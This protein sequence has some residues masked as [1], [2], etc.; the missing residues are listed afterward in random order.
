MLGCCGHGPEDSP[1]KRNARIDWTSIAMMVVTLASL[2]V[3]LVVVLR[4]QGP[5]V[6]TTVP[7]PDPKPGPVERSIP[8]EQ[9]YATFESGKVQLLASETSTDLRQIMR[10]SPWRPPDVFLIRAGAKD[11]QGVIRAGRG[12]LLG[13]RPATGVV[14]EEGTP[15]DAPIW[16]MCYLGRG[17][18]PPRWRLAAVSLTENR[19]RIALGQRRTPAPVNDPSNPLFIFA[20]L[21]QLKEGTYAVEL[22]EEGDPEP[23]LTRRVDCRES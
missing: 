13:H 17:P 14:R 18:L 15:R 16:V 11:I 2:G 22:G 9:C 20:P 4:E 8:L 12:V 19:A 7:P 21:G 6:R 1:S 23:L 10:D 3:A 5:Q